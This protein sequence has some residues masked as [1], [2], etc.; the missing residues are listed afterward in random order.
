MMKKYMIGI[1]I[2]MIAVAVYGQKVVEK[3]I[4]LKPETGIRFKLDFADTIHI[5]QSKDNRLRIT[6]NVKINDNQHNDKYELITGGDS[7]FIT[8]KEKIHDMESI[9]IPCNKHHGINFE[10]HDGKCISMDIRYIIEVPV[11]AD[12]HLETISGNIILDYAKSPMNIES[13]S[14]F[15][16]LTIPAGSNLDVTLKTVT[17]GIYINP[18]ITV[19]RDNFKGTPGGTETQFKMGSGGNT[20]KLSTI[21]NDIFVR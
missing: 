2:S 10:S 16:D 21:S 7:D 3:Q 6:A 5:K 20:I 1:I 14:G 11:A 13:V 18:E 4:G 9:R 19:N 8:I 15:I 17:G 12:L